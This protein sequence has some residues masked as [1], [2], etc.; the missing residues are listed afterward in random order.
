MDYKNLCFRDWLLEQIRDEKEA[1][2]RNK[3]DPM[4]YT[5]WGN[6][7]AN[8]RMKEHTFLAGIYEYVLREYDARAN[9]LPDTVK[10]GDII[11]SRKGKW[12]YIDGHLVVLGDGAGSNT[13]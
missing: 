8:E 13:P 9:I 1:V 10:D 12:V 5:E 2:T 11:E 4:R 7:L 6:Q 3:N